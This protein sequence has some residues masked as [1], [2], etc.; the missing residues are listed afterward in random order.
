MPC[1]AHIV[2]TSGTGQRHICSISVVIVYAVFV[3]SFA[4]KHSVIGTVANTNIDQNTL[5]VVSGTNGVWH[6]QYILIWHKGIF[7]YMFS[8]YE[9]SVKLML[10][11]LGSSIMCSVTSLL[12][13]STATHDICVLIT[14]HY[15]ATLVYRAY[16]IISFCQCSSVSHTCQCNHLLT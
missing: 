5:P 7:H 15:V 8:V 1:H 4:C 16:I 12:W 10:I 9:I 13:W 2:H 3:F 14:K 11:Q 6:N